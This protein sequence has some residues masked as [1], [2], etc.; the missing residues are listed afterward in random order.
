MKIPIITLASAIFALSSCKPSESDATANTVDTPAKETS[1]TEATAAIPYPLKTCPV[2]GEE[3][4]SMGKPPVIV[5]QGQQIKFCCKNCIPN[6]NKE[7]DKFIAKLGKTPLH[8]IP[9]RTWMN[10]E[11]NKYHSAGPSAQVV[12]T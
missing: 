1:E 10:Y 2:S 9:L 6:F 8:R 3:L 12:G 11:R 5:H 7:P 4:G